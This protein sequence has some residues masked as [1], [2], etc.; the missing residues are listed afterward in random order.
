[1]QFV[2]QYLDRADGGNLRALHRDAHI[3]F[4]RSLGKNLLL[5][6]PLLSESGAPIGSLVLIEA[7][8]MSAARS[9]AVADPYAAAGLFREIEVYGYRIM[10][11]HLPASS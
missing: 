4:R 5:A 8:D 9:T 7:A 10:A 3:A 6:G 2:V 1:M 11:N